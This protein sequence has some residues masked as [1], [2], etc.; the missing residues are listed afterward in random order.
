VR[1]SSGKPG[2]AHPMA[3]VPQTLTEMS[4]RL[5]RTGAAH[6][7]IVPFWGYRGPRLSDLTGVEPVDSELIVESLRRVKSSAELDCIQLSCD[8]AV[9]AHRRMQ[10]AI[11]TGKPEMEGY[12]PASAEAPCEMVHAMLG[13]PPRGKA[14]SGLIAMFAAGRLS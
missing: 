6:D 8:W 14:Y 7:G 2:P 9:R 4:A 3:S 1:I 13:W 12:M 11:T 10:G 5:D